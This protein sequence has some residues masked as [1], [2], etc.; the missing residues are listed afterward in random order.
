MVDYWMPT[1]SGVEL[2]DRLRHRHV[3]LPVIL[4]TARA[5]QDMRRR[6]AGAGFRQV[7]E[8][9]LE[10]GARLDGIRDALAVR[11]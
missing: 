9:P 3:D 8:K 5:A 6:A 2:V 10:D 7:L 4:I 1:M 11:A